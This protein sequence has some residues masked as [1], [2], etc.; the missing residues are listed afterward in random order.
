MSDT[1]TGSRA[2]ICRIQAWLD[3]CD[4][5]H[6]ACNKGRRQEPPLPTRVLKVGGK[7]SN[8]S[9]LVSGHGKRGNYATLSHCWG[10]PQHQP[11][12]TTDAT[13]KNRQR[14]IHD[15]ELPLTFK[16]AVYLC[17]E[18]GIGFLW[19]DS[20]CIIQ[21]QV[22]QSDWAR[23]APTM[24]NVYGNSMLTIA[25]GNAADSSSGCFRERMGLMYWP[26]PIKVLGQQCH[27]ARY[28]TSNEEHSGDPG[29]VKS[30]SL[31]DP[32]NAR[33]WVLQEQILS[34]RSII[35]AKNC[36]VWR[37]ASMATNEKYPLGIPHA[38]NITADNYRLLHCV[39]N[40]TLDNKQDLSS[41]DIYTC[42]YRIVQSFTSRGITY[43]DDRLPAIAGIAKK[44]Y[45]VAQDS[46]CAGLWRK[47]LFVGLLWL[48][49]RRSYKRN[50]S[51]RAPTWSWA[52]VNGY[53]SYRSIISA[54]PDATHIPMSPLLDI[55]GI[56]DPKTCAQHPFGA[57]S[58]ATLRVSGRLIPAVRDEYSESGLAL[59]HHGTR[60]ASDLDFFGPDE[61]DIEPSA[62]SP[63]Y[64][65][66]VSVQHDPYDDGIR[67]DPEPYRKSWEESLGTG[68]DKFRRFNKVSCMVL[69]AVP[70]KQE[71]Y[72][73]V[74]V[75]LVSRS[76]GC[77]IGK[78][79]L[80]DR[81]TFTII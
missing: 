43:K 21:D 31:E 41:I 40:N 22:S 61:C 78:M 10:G 49:A 36:L 45:A 74:G 33:A 72:R 79:C 26:C 46:Y 56:T 60:H 4:S 38:P 52:S 64:C 12:R 37:C 28:P 80:E 7:Q 6:A 44:F 3:I 66:P 73:R 71:T 69:E 58:R 30:S 55:L 68:V 27:V 50:R 77:E 65:L 15:A 16:D 76:K 39:I 25:A 23:E 57:T 48:S 63:W 19:I 81:A 67:G 62:G 13:L 2:S 34:R 20:L 47:D 51:S 70:G 5:S 42:W 75:G 18:L 14:G 17:R 54:G 8:K 1:S 53:V 59:I 32:L 29:D 35:F 24:G 9:F 11:L